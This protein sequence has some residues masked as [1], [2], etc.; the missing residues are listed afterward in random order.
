MKYNCL[1][2][3]PICENEEWYLVF[4]RNSNRAGDPE[5]SISVTGFIIYLL[6]ALIRWRS[7]GQ[8][9][10][11]LS[12]SEAEYVAMSEAFKEIS[13]IYFLLKGMGI[14][15]KLLTVVRCDNFGAIS[16]LKTQVQELEHVIL[17]QG[18]VLLVKMLKMN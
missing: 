11:T 6:G 5:T 3:N 2:M 10:V 15:F 1:K 13:F 18:I 14:D 17:I 7:K 9:G 16:W 8:K 4:Y 12:S